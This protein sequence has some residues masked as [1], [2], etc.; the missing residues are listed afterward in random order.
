MPA[1]PLR[2]RP[3]IR[4]RHVL[5]LRQRLRRARG[6]HGREPLIVSLRSAVSAHEPEAAK[7]APGELADAAPSR[8]RI[9]RQWGSVL[10]ILMKEVA[11]DRRT[12]GARLIAAA[13]VCRPVSGAGR[14]IH[15]TALLG[16]DDD[17]TVGPL[18]FA[19]RKSIPAGV[20]SARV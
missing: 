4:A 5:E 6:V 13:A 19:G 3:G 20:D 2:A 9:R 18:P 8:G 15:R 7:C 17:V 1:A 12:P 11:A 14:R 10:T 16:C